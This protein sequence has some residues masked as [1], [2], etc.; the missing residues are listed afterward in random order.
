M[1]ASNWYLFYS[2]VN[3][4]SR[5]VGASEIERVEFGV[6]SKSIRVTPAAFSALSRGREV[7]QVNSGD[8]NI[9]SCMMGGFEVV[10]TLQLPQPGVAKM[11]GEPLDID[12][13]VVAEAATDEGVLCGEDHSDDD[14]VLYADADKAILEQTTGGA[15]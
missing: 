9:R 7:S 13:P 1:D 6:G 10:M 4:V 11:P 3:R 2:F 14:T 8:F 5:Y 15:A 12:R